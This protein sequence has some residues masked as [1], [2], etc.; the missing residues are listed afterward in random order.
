MPNIRPQFLIAEMKS[1]KSSPWRTKLIGFTLIELLVVVAIIAIL[2]GLLLPALARAKAKALQTQCLNNLKQIGLALRMYGDDNGDSCPGPLERG[3]KAGYYAGTI[4]QPVD[5]IYDYL[6]LQSPASF[7]SVGNLEYTTPIFTCPVQIQ[8]IVPGI[9]PG[10]RI[11]YADRGEI[12][13]GVQ[14]SRPFGYPSGTTPSVPGSPYPPLTMGSLNQYTN[15][16]SDCYAIRDVDQQ[17]DNPSA[18]GAAAWYGQITPTA[19]HKD[20]IRNVLY[21]DWH[22]QATKYT[23]YLE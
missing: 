11:T 5:F 9:L 10:N 14:T 4:N 13:G 23:N 19:A 1:N 18:P 7:P 8:Y 20:N 21:F 2:A 16:L 12:I 6:G 15:D 3:I 22:A 17:L